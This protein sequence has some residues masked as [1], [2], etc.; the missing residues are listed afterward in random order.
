M[1]TSI[2]LG[3]FKVSLV[4]TTGTNTIHD[5]GEEAARERLQNAV[6]AAKS[7]VSV[8]TA[9]SSVYETC[10]TCGRIYIKNDINCLCSDPFHC[11]RDCVWQDGGVVERCDSHKEGV[12]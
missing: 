7:V 9:E 12:A 3:D 2:T 4:P 10:A 1:K 5:L 11:C 8:P 6:D